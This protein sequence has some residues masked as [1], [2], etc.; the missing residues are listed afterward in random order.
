MHTLRYLLFGALASIIVTP[1]H[2]QDLISRY[3]KAR[4]QQQVEYFT[5]DN[6]V[7]AQPGAVQYL[8]T[9]ADTIQQ[10]L[11]QLTNNARISA[12]NSR[13]KSFEVSDWRLVRKFERSWFNKKFERTLWAYLGTEPLLRVDTTFTRE[14]RSKLEAY[15]GPPTQTISELLSDG[16]PNARTRD[17]H[18]Q[19]EYWF[20]V[21]DSIPV[22]LMDVN[23][24][25]ER[26]LIVSSDQRY[27]D[28]LL[29][30]RESLLKEFMNSKQRAPYIDYYFDALLRAW[31]YVGF[32]G[33]SYF[34]EP[35]GQPNLALG[36]P[37]LDI[38]NRID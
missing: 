12:W 24:P 7:K 30:V 4:F 36:R 32:D 25:L 2:G 34:Y 38:I 8:P 10:W 21:N 22:V 27:R 18:I 3:R 37:W 33:V 13:E 23:G 5:E 31:Y 1:L 16:E 20:V 15:Y 29:Q 35:I 26:G 14:L 28:I 11:N 17:R 9:R 6:G 19:F